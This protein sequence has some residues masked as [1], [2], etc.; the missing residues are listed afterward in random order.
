MQIPTN[1]TIHDAGR[2]IVLTCFDMFCVVFIPVDSLY[3]VVAHLKPCQVSRYAK[4]D[5]S[6]SNLPREACNYR[7]GRMCRTWDCGVPIGADST[8]EASMINQPSVFRQLHGLLLLAIA[9]TAPHFGGT[10]TAMDVQ[11]ECGCCMLRASWSKKEL[12]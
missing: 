10:K 7:I 5:S 1:C 9:S 2:L 3:L 4:R 11:E 6:A 8:F 12:V